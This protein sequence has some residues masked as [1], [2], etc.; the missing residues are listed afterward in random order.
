MINLMYLVL[1][2]MLALNVSAE[3]INAFF[4]LDKG[5]KGTTKIVT[6]ANGKV[7]E[8]MEKAI[9]KRPDDKPLVDAAK[10]AQVIV[11]EFYDYV[12][13]LRSTLTEKAGGVF[14]G[15][16]Q[17]PGDGTGSETEDETKWGKPVK[18]KNKEIPQRL[19]VDGNDGTVGDEPAYE[20]EGPILKKK[21]EETKAK[22]KALLLD[23]GKKNPIV[24][25]D[26]VTAVIEQLSL[27]IDEKGPKAADK[28]WE[29][30][31]FG[32]MPVAAVYPMITKF[33]ADA[34]NSEAAIINFLA[35]KIGGAVL[36]FDKFQPVAAVDKG[37]IISGDRFSA[38]IFLSAASKQAKYSVRVNGS[39]LPVKEGVAKYST[40][41]SSTGEKSYKVDIT[42]KNPFNG[43]SETFSKTFKYEVGRRS[44]TVSADKMN[45]LYVGVKNPISVVA[46]GVSSN[47][48]KVSGSG[49]GLTLTKSGSGYIA[50]VTKPGSDATITVSGGGLDPTRFKF[51]VFRIPNPIPK[52]GR[53]PT[54]KGGKIGAGTFKGQKGVYADLEDFVFDA[55]CTIDGFELTRVPARQDPITERNQG[56]TFRGRV[57]TLVGM[58]KPGDIYYIDAIKGRCPGD[59]AGRQL[60]GMI[61]K[62]K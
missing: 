11:K 13:E 10:E 42:L 56:G 61:F 19:F 12:G 37:Y 34:K 43:K 52:V 7:V 48:L 54:E 38:D 58:A 45:A 31:N 46:A 24:T 30:Y 27:S 5:L 60:G 47:K 32:H 44:V 36:E 59:R 62:I 22:L 17:A 51:R 25:D 16:G 1:T 9:E 57:A 53:G 35:S 28:S 29:D 23:V 20:P 21:V 3:V 15:P 49:G 14:Y 2:A 6:T 8:S 18:Y 40:G 50:N 26:E 39:N 4:K 33:Q 41:T 55:R